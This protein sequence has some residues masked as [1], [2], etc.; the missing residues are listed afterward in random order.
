MDFGLPARG[1]SSIAVNYRQAMM[2]AIAPLRGLGHRRIGLIGGPAHGAAAQRRKT[3][4]LE[5]V[6]TNGLEGRAIDSDFSVQGGYFSC[7][8]LLASY[9]CTAV[10][11]ANDLMAIGALHLAHE[12]RIAVP[13][14]L[15][16]IGF[17]DIAFAQFTQPALTTVAAPRAEIGRVAFNSLSALMKK[18]GTPGETYDIPT[19]LVVRQTTAGVSKN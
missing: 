16:I 8:T 17:D 14:R 13:E 18:S 9:A 11:A 12:Q 6:E 2:E 7:S 1:I 19:H 4:F 5:G 15:S 3:A 10:I